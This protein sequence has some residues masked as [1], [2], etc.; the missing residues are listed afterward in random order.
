[1]KLEF[2][3]VAFKLFEAKEL[4][5]K[6]AVVLALVCMFS[7]QTKDK[8]KGILSQA[9]LSALLV[10]IYLAEARLDAIPKVKDSTIR[11]FVPFEQKL[12]QR[13]GV[14]DSVLKTTYDYY[15]ANPKELEQV[16]D[17]VI[18]TLTLRE[19]RANLTPLSPKPV[20]PAE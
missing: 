19:Q 7:C 17:S 12:L 10:D 8:P 11:Y 6:I 1:M 4:M 18:D 2:L 14:S 9:Q 16:Y 5:R 13:H 15:L 20:R 3:E